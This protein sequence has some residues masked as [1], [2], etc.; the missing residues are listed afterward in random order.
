MFFLTQNAAAALR[1]S[2]GG[3]E[4]QGQKRKHDAVEEV[5]EDAEQDSRDHVK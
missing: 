1:K 4:Q 3:Q 2:F 5:D